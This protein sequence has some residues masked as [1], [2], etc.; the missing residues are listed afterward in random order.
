[1][2]SAARTTTSPLDTSSTS[3]TSNDAVSLDTDTDD[4]DATDTAPL[5]DRLADPDA[6][7]TAPPLTTAMSSD[8]VTDARAADASSDVDAA[9]DTTSLATLTD[10]P[11]L[12][13]TERPADTDTDSDTTDSDSPDT[14]SSTLADDTLTEPPSAT[15]PKWN[16]TCSQPSKLP[17]P[18]GID[19]SRIDTTVCAAKD[20]DTPSIEYE[21][22]PSDDDHTDVHDVAVEPSDSDTSVPP[23]DTTRAPDAAV[24]RISTCSTSVIDGTVFVN[25]ANELDERHT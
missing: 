16:T 11:P 3:D 6:T 13:S 15:R 4:P 17:D 9:T 7:D 1:M 21:P 25:S 19:V 2:R 10:S 23:A 18:D 20:T 12:T 22:A 24:L 14:A 8:T 5:L